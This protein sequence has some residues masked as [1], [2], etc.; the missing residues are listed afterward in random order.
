[1]DTKI[2]TQKNT[3]INFEKIGLVCG[4]EIHQQVD[5]KKLFCSCPS[6]I[7]DDSPTIIIKRKLRASAGETGIVDTAALHEIERN[8]YFIYEGYSENTCLVDFDEEPPHTI[9]AHALHTALQVSLLLKGTIVEDIQ[10]MRKTVLDGS[11]TSG[12]Q[13]TALVAVDGHISING[14]NI[15]I[16]SIAIEEEAA[17]KI[18]QNNESTTYRLDRLG[19][20]LIKIGTGPDIRTP[21]EAKQVS[22]YLGM[23][24][25]STGKVKRGLGTIRQDVN[26]SIAGG[27][28]V[29][30]K[31]AQDLKLIPTLIEYE[32]QRQMSLLEIKKELIEKKIE[33]NTIEIK[34]LTDIF[35][36]T[37]S[38]ILKKAIENK[39]KV[40]G[41]KCT[42]F[43][44]FLG[45]E[46]Q[47]G[48]RLGTE[49]STRAKIASGVGGLFHSDELLSKYKISER[50]IEKIKE[51]L[52]IKE[53]DA[54]ILV[55]DKEDLS[56]RALHAANTRLLE[57]WDG[58][59]KEVRKA[60]EDGTTTFMRP[61]PG[62]NRM[63]PETDVPTIRPNSKNII[64]PELLTKKADRLKEFGLQNEVASILSKSGKTELFI[65]FVQK[66]QNIKP[67]FI[68]EIYTSIE[69]VLKRKYAVEEQI[70]DE[71]YESIFSAL[72]MGK[73]T[74]E[75][76]ETIFLE[77]TKTKKIDFTKYTALTTE[78]LQ[79]E[80]TAIKKENKNATKEQILG[81]I[82]SK[83]RGKADAQKI[84][85]LLI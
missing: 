44:G 47:T 56:I 6:T 75:S 28:R 67:S 65:D 13:R 46:I 57:C 77:Y 53:N 40:L 41:I 61:M 63:Y 11:N 12:F 62:A 20:P 8:K 64:L 78:Q 35:S 74:K 27:T 21:E 51:R 43:S 50:E 17:R 79:E 4:I 81:L 45:R 2:N 30:I 15:S 52:E 29:E 32:A 14:K 22:E 60:N 33:K 76:L 84:K 39:G 24:L 82:M 37:E 38:L 73:I 66:F 26:V 10:V 58:V 25:R 54:F 85:E 36:K 1:M 5:T 68:A 48:K 83:L 71:T 7:R 19:I 49:C 55:A 18:S 16:P 3:K 69:K 9:D 42:L 72:N 70:T 34:D 23:I 59:P 31:G 80:I